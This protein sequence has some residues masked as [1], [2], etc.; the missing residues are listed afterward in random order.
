MGFANTLSSELTNIEA[1]Y[2]GR[3]GIY[4]LNTETGKTFEYRANERFPL[5][6]SFKAF[7]AAAVLYKDQTAP[8]LLSERIQYSNREMEPHSPITGKF[9]QLGMTA[10]EMAAA[11]IQYSDNGAANILM[12]RYIKGP[13]G[14]TN[15]MRS[16]GDEKFRLDRW[17]IELNS[18]I[19][20]DQRDTSTPRAVAE[21]INKIISGKVLDLHHQKEFEKWMIGNKTGDTRI[22]SAVP[23]GWVVGDKTGTCGNYGAANDIAFI[24][25]Q[26]SKSPWIISIYTTKNEKNIKHSD[27]IIS[28]LASI[29]IKEIQ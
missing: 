5:C 9:Q 14:M 8:G 20:G 22:R 4:A 2:N 24:W 15:F 1:D 16:I 21:S 19:P 6:S 11:S 28:K 13:E 12:E 18:A 25:P 26:N 10:S 3:L 7:L 17:E 23:N 29:A 27:S